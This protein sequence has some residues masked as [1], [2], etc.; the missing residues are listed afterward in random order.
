MDS[1]RQLLRQPLKT[2]SGILLVAL[3]VAV[4]TVSFS[5]TLAASNTAEKLKQTFVTVALPADTGREGAE[6]WL[7]AIEAEYPGLIQAEIRHGLASAYIPELTQ[8]NLTS[9]LYE[10]THLN[11]NYLLEPDYPVYACAMLEITLTDI[12]DYGEIIRY[13]TTTDGS[14]L[15][16]AFSGS[17]GYCLRGTVERVIGLEEGYQDPTGY[18]VTLYI[19]DI[20]ISGLEVGQH[21]LVYSSSY[22][23]LD[24][25]VRSWLVNE[26][27]VL[28]WEDGVEVPYWKSWR[29]EEREVT[30]WTTDETGTH[31]DIV[32]E[33][34]LKA[35]IGDLDHRIVGAE[36]HMFRTVE[37]TLEDLSG[38]YGAAY[39]K[40]TITRLDGTAEEFL[41]SS[42][43]ALWRQALE[44]ISINTHAYAVIGVEN[45]NYFADFACGLAEIVEGRD[46]TPEELA[47]GAK[48]CIL[49]KSLA[50]ANGLGVGDTI[51][52][53]FFTYDYEN[54][55]QD[56]ISQGEGVIKPTAYSYFGSTMALNDQ[57]SYTIVGLY[58]QDEPWGSVDNNLYQF[59]PNT[60]FAPKASISGSM[61]ESEDAMFRTLILDGDRLYELQMLSVEAGMDGIFTYDDNG[62]TELAQSLRGYQQAAEEMLPLGV[63]VYAVLSLL[64]LFL[65]P[66][67]QGSQIAMM[68]SLGAGLGRKVRHCITS[69]LGILIPGTVLG[70][71]AGLY[72][73]QYVSDALAAYME[74][75]VVVELN[76][77][78]LICVSGLQAILLTAAAAVIGLVLAKRKNLMRG[79]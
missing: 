18:S 59:T 22:L 15:T 19:E 38:E 21:Y 72:L 58:E 71:A 24:W 20:D 10:T 54:P 36:E 9:H 47:D 43:G 34:I 42:D 61:D 56:L 73:W 62:Y 17:F 76:A 79:K 65:F 35:R 16:A 32:I 25:I 74:T 66:G 12:Q 14:G 52:A 6:E 48:V 49:S 33:E 53:Q 30:V 40:P 3:A 5:Q 55:Y 39:A 11:E 60:V 46:F 57:D 78:D 44:D 45:M 63:L 1:L 67:R 37:L 26:D 7:D 31:L 13:R 4:L 77:L 50:V 75:G 41:A 69:C 2:L 8:D 64:Y 28:I 70:T 29:I 27:K 51:T 68:D 23:D